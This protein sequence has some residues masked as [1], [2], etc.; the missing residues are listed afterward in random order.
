[1]RQDPSLGAISKCAVQRVL[2]KTTPAERKAHL[3]E[4]VGRRDNNRRWAFSHATKKKL[5]KKRPE[6]FKV[7]KALYVSDALLLRRKKNKDVSPNDLS[8][9]SPFLASLMRVL[10]R[11]R[12][13]LTKKKDQRAPEASTSPHCPP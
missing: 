4:T 6:D 9:A 1:M 5:K 3:Q 10:L 2:G 7:D 8:V 12:M 13:P 11:R